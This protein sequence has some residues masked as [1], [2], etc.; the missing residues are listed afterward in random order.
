MDTRSRCLEE[1]A[2]MSYLKKS[3][4]KSAFHNIERLVVTET[5]KEKKRGL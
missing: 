3:L 2:D 5:I 4:A 1:P